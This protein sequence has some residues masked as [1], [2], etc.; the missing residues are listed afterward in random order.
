VENCVFQDNS[1]A[2]IQV[3]C[4]A[5]SWWEG[6]P[7]RNV[8][9]RDNTISR[10]NFGMGAR[11]AA[12]DIFAENTTGK[13]SVPVHQM[14]DIQHNTISNPTGAAIHVGSAEHVTIRNN[15]FKPAGPANV[16]IDNSRDVQATGN[17]GF[18]DVHVK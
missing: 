7:T 1:G 9:I 15:T 8:T 18:A 10:S 5:R 2:A 11:L 16:I 14:I 6:M 13:P 12:I 4:D 3:T 17:D